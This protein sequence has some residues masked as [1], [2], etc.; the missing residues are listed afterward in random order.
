MPIVPSHVE[1][2]EIKEKHIESERIDTKSKHII[3]Y[4]DWEIKQKSVPVYEIP[5]EYCKYRLEN[6]RIKTQIL[7]HVKLKGKLNPNDDETQK[8]IS[9]YLGKSDPTKNEDLKKSLDFPVAS[10]LWPG[11][12]GARVA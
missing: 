9:E 2:D 8:V 5:I 10:R 3:P 7:T 1:I 4:K 6:G 11:L 12:G